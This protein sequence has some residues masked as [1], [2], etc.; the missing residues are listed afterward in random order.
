MVSPRI[1]GER[2]SQGVIIIRADARLLFAETDIVVIV[3]V[4]IR[5][6]GLK[7]KVVGVV[8]REAVDEDVSTLMAV[9]VK[10]LDGRSDVATEGNAT[11]GIMDTFGG[12]T[13]TVSAEFDTITVSG[14]RGGA[15]EVLLYP[16]VIRRITGL[17]SPALGED[18]V[19]VGLKEIP[20][21][22]GVTPRAAT[23]EAVTDTI[24]HLAGKTI[25]VGAVVGVVIAVM[26]GVTIDDVVVG[27]MRA[28]VAVDAREGVGELMSEAELDTGIE[29]IGELAALDA[30]V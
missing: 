18:Y 29:V 21:V 13:G 26:M 5:T 4:G 27:T 9:A 30:V 19:V 11:I 2:G 24:M 10:A 28:I 6:A 16:E 20:C 7:H 14:E 23:D 15:V 17:P 25:R 12:S 1:F 3:G 22:I 8:E